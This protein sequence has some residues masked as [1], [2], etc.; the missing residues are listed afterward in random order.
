MFAVCT[1]TLDQLGL[2]IL[3]ARIIATHEDIALISFHVL[4]DTGSPIPD[5][6]REQTVVNILRRNLL[7]PEQ[8][9]LSVDRHKTRQSKYFDTP[10]TIQFKED[11]QKRFTILEINTHDQPGVLSII[12]QC[13]S[14]CRVNVRN[15][16]ITTLGT[17]AEDIFYL[18]DSNNQMI[19]DKALLDRL[20]ALLIKELSPESETT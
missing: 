5:L 9:V 3:D 19:T 16:K 6:S 11:H 13:F 20:E 8:T 12:G 7:N 17:V 14:T 4:E 10:T 15:A 1:A 18:T 2:N